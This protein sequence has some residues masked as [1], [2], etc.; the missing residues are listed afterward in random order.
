MAHKKCKNCGKIFDTY[1]SSSYL[2]PECADEVRKKSSIRPRV[3][4]T[5]GR[6]FD[7]GPR[8][9]YCP[10]CRAERKKNRNRTQTN[11]P[12]GS[13][14]I[15]QRCGE[16]YI[17]MSW[18]QK[19]CEKCADEAV[20]E[21]VRAHKKEVREK[22]KEKI[23]KEKNERRTPLKVCVICG[24]EFTSKTPT[25]VCSEECEKELKRRRQEIGD[26]K[27]GRR[28]LEPG[29]KPTPSNNPKSGIPGITW[30]KQTNRWQTKKSKKYIGLYKTIEEAQEALKEYE[31]K[32]PS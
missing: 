24:K 10:E 11:R 27:R 18:R 23:Y 25:K 6:T 31:S 22:N 13:T 7:G 14:D 12:I 28:K 15:C 4:K 21:K 29:I 16:P 5:C 32:N 17:V 3:C 26:F 1:K 30:H 2:C 8:A 9:W 20:K 19:Y